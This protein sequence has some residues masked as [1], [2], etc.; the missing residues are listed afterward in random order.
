MSANVVISDELIKKIAKE[1][2]VDG[3]NLNDIKTKSEE[4]IKNY[5]LGKLQK[6]DKSKKSLEFLFGINEQNPNS[7]T[8]VLEY[9]K[10]NIGNFFGSATSWSTTKIL[11]YS[12]LKSKPNKTWN[13]QKSEIG[14][15][16]AIIR[17]FQ[18]KNNL[19]SVLT[20]IEENTT[21]IEIYNSLKKYNNLPT[22]QNWLKKYLTILYPDKFMPMLDID[23]INK[24]F[25]PLN[26]IPSGTDPSYDKN[27]FENCDKFSKKAS[28]LNL[29]AVALYHVVKHSID[30]NLTDESISN[31]ISYLN[32]YSQK[33]IDSKNVI[34]RGAPGTGKSYLAKEIA[35]YIISNKRTTKYDEL[36]DDEKAQIE[37]V[38][39]HPSYDYADFVEG[40]RPTVN[41]NQLG[42]E[43]RDGIFKSFVERARENFEASQNDDGD[44]FV[45]RKDYVFIIDEINRGEISKILGE[46][47]FAID[48]G[49]RGKEGAVS[50]QYSN[51]HDD[52]DKKFYIPENVYIIGTMND[53]DR[54]VD[55]FDFA[56]RRRFRFIEIDAD[57]RMEMLDELG[58]NVKKDVEKRMKSLNKS[59]AETDGLGKNYQIGAAYYLKLESI[60]FDFDILWSDYLKPLL[61]EYVNGMYGEQEIMQKFHNAYH[62]NTSEDSKNENEN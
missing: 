46:L 61:Q 51:L 23:W 12:Q 17:S 48:P 62:I 14:E 18:I 28:D 22:N 4:F 11:N 20:T 38:Q 35:A 8:Y 15:N 30:N 19:I 33:V 50:T 55:T 5:G 37:F 52:P 41:G 13:Q 3:I 34:F 2:L 21:A 58:E 59:I 45:E 54:S 29:T 24:I 26:I 31:N 49:Y 6:L 39:F 32:E 53:I 7:L 56:M 27:W 42:F 60:D 25:T 47:F 16:E 1:P 40:L 10:N 44:K 9:D 57:K 36:N 43:L